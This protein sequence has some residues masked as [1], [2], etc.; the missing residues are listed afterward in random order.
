MN[1]SARTVIGAEPTLKLNQLGVP[2]DV[3]QILTKPETVTSFNIDW[4]TSLVD[5]GKANFV[6]ITRKK[7]GEMCKTRLNLQYALHNRGTR[8]LYGDIIFR[9]SSEKDFLKRDKKGK[10]V[11]SEDDKR[12]IRV[13]T[14]NET[15]RDGDKLI[16]N[17]EVTEVIY[18]SKKQLKLR[19][20]DI[21][22]RQI[23]E[24]CI[25]LL[26]RQPTKKL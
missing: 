11:F 19:Y 4:L 14:G 15:L 26:N 20:G 10:I 3:C 23:S 13:S 18:P 9:P 2:R 6:T 17:G 21:V 24:G 12:F 8:L 1:Y 25:A 7:D 5:E 22:E 16:R